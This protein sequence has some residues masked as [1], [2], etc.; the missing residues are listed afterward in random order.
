MKFLQSY[1]PECLQKWALLIFFK[2]AQVRTGC[3]ASHHRLSLCCKMEQV[4]LINIRPQHLRFLSH[5]LLISF[6]ISSLSHPQY[7]S[8]FHNLSCRSLSTFCGRTSSGGATLTTTTMWTW[9]LSSTPSSSTR[10]EN[11]GTSAKHPPPPL[12]RL[13]IP[14]VARW[15]LLYKL[16]KTYQRYHSKSNFHLLLSSSRTPH[17]GLQLA[18]LVS[19]CPELLLFAWRPLLWTEA[20]F[21]LVLVFSI[22]WQ[23]TLALKWGIL[24]C[25]QVPFLNFSFKAL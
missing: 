15:D 7:L 13:S 5:I 9:L 21:R 12:S 8:F 20:S 25:V 22:W 6:F 19:A 3:P 1:I 16:K 2:I 18:A 23:P 11:L 17:S 10:L 4:F 14:R 24:T